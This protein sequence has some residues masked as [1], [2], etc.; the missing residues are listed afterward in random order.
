MKI[1]HVNFHGNPS[2]GGGPGWYM[3]TDRQEDAHD[4]VNRS[5]SRI[6]DRAYKT[7]PW[8]EILS[9]HGFT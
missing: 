4:K 9:V 8:K 1:P 5:S 2:S 6:C 7:I 3:R